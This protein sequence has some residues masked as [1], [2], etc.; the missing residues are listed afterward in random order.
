MKIKLFSYCLLTGLLLGSCNDKVFQPTENGVIVR[1]QQKNE[2]QPQLVRLQVVGE[3]LI[4]VSATPLGKFS[5]EKS[6]IAIPP[7][8]QV[9]FTVLQSGDTI[10]VSTQEVKASVLSSTGEVWFTDKNGKLILQE[11]KG[12]GKHFI[13]IEIEGRKGYTI[14]QVFE[15]PDNEAFYFPIV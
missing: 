14:R 4:H 8:E 15:S 11:N 1:I 13:P 3:K 5:K 6:L 12:G 10:S 9:P 7:E 2:N